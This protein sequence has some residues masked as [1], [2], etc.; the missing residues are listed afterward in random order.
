[1]NISKYFTGVCVEL[2]RS[3]IHFADYNPREINEE[4]KKNIKRGIKKFGLLGGLVVN[5]RTGFTIV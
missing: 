3:Q 5:K 1:M 4:E 2:K